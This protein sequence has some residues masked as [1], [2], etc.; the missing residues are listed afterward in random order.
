MVICTLQE[1]LK[2]PET[3][4][5]IPEIIAAFQDNLQT[6]LSPLQI[7]QLACLG[8]QMPKSNIIFSS[9]PSGT[10]WSNRVY[11]PLAKKDLFIWEADFSEV[12]AYVEQFEAG[13]W[14]TISPLPLAEPESGTSGCQ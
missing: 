14:P 3:V 13:T 2:S 11:D 6:D 10:F 5:K 4:S 1:K 12:S 8:I 7:T 9:F